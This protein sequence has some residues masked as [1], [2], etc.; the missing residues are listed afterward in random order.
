MKKFTLS[1]CAALFVAALFFVFACENPAQD[2]KHI[3]AYEE[4]IIPRGTAISTAAELAKI[5]N[6]DEYPLSGVYY[7]A[8]DIDLSGEEYTPWTPIG[9]AETPFT[10]WFNGNDK[11]VSSL[12]LGNSDDTYVGLFGYAKVAIIENLTV[13]VANDLDEPIILNLDAEQSIGAVIG[14][15]QY[16]RIGYLAVTAAEGKGL[17]IE[18]SAATSRNLNAGGIAGVIKNSYK[19]ITNDLHSEIAI[20]VKASKI[21]TYIGGIVGTLNDSLLRGSAGG[22]IEVDAYEGSGITA[23][24]L[25]GINGGEENHFIED[26]ESRV[27]KVTGIQRDATASSSFILGG[28]TG[29]GKVKNGVLSSKAEISAY[30]EYD[31][32]GSMTL[33]G[34]SGTTG[35]GVV[36]CAVTDEATISAFSAGVHSLQ[37]GGLTGKG[38]VSEGYIPVA[39]QIKA[40]KTK[41]ASNT[42]IILVGGLTGGSGMVTDSYSFADIT[43][44]TKTTTTSPTSYIS[45]IGGISGLLGN[46]VTYD[47]LI[48]RTYSAGKVEVVNNGSGT[49]SV[50]GIV[51][52]VKNV[53]VYVENNM[54]L[55]PE[56]SGTGSG[57]FA[58][59]KIA[60][61]KGGS[62]VKMYANAALDSSNFTVKSE[63]IA[64]TNVGRE[65][66]SGS[67]IGSTASKADFE[68]TGWD[69]S[70]TSPWAWDSAK[71]V[72]VLKWASK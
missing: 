54:A 35:W 16:S 62:S 36:K 56:V 69:F 20:K 72:P 38:A 34:I 17:N 61:T 49:L 41:T 12:T 11:T 57:S 45:G 13:D 21:K 7:L 43:V 37:V 1:G 40:T 60:G 70:T 64:D 4:T 50:G 19:D 58:L 32:S 71:G 48:A 44:D 18:K 15:A 6:D 33:G 22:S 9:N 25:V 53:A 52:Y 24:G 28:I 31:T 30:S 14:M 5:G 39:V 3:T 68:A 46:N 65:N 2:P 27:S 29:S 63:S 66:L 42:S 67:I 26:V 23:G 47:Y 10:G 8:E 51:G 59:E 55:N